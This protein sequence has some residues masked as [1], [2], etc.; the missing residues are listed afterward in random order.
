MNNMPTSQ[1]ASVTPRREFLKGSAAV[2][3]AA[4]LRPPRL[5]AALFAAQPAGTFIDVTSAPYNAVGDGVANDR[6]SFQAA[7]NAAVKQK[8]PLWVPSPSNFYRIEL[9]SKNPSLTM[10]GHVDIMGAGRSSTLL[11]FSISNPDPALRYSGFTI[12]NGRRLR[13]YDLRLEE[14]VKARDFE[15][16]GFTFPSGDRNHTSEIVR[17]DVDG[18]T[19]V[20]VSP[21]S[22]EGDKKGELFLTIRGCDFKPDL[23]YCVAFWTIENGHKR[24]HCYDSYFHDNKESHLIYCH[25][26]N[27]VH[28]ENCRFDGAT[29]WA[30]HFQGSAVA[31]E[32][33]YQRFIGCWFGN[34]NSRSIITQHRALVPTE[35]EV[36]NCVF[37]GRPAIQIRSNIVIDGCYFTTPLDPLPGNG[38]VGAYEDAPWKAVIRNCIFALR[39]GASPAV[40]MRLA[41]IEV[42]IENCQFYSQKSATMV[43]MGGSSK[44]VFQ[45]A[46]CLFYTR[47]GEGNFSKIIEITDGQITIRRCRFAGPV[48][49]DRGLFFFAKADVGP[50]PESRLQIDD[51]QFNAISG[52]TL[53][54]VTINGPDTWSERIFGQNNRIAAYSSDKPMLIVEPGS[55]PVFAFLN[56]VAE[57]A[58]ATLAAGPMLVI[59]SNYDQYTISSIGDINTIHWWFPDGLSNAL[60]SGVVTLSAAAGFTLVSGGN[61]DL[62]GAPSLVVAAGDAV[63][64]FYDPTRQSWSVVAS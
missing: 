4:L 38:F 7:I 41:N 47:T 16:N 31:G 48:T 63:R 55:T 9:D 19:H 28:I 50:G 26:H 44:N 14:D 57:A 32:P 62:E 58:P 29:S 36:I 8:V 51:C 52:G 37:E 40:D 17:V 30:F 11:R 27:S 56:P 54:Y 13:I 60:F 39:T 35:V 61:I 25:P 59:S 43:A 23:Q 21:S 46:N 24:L 42:T 49:H 12:P 34:R 18:F 1:D 10:N 53:F 20:V 2:V 6:P 64:L 33:E 22:G 15:F 3:A 5:P 45:I